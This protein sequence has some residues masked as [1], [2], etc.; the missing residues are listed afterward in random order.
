MNLLAILAALALEQWR[1]FR[2]RNPLERAFVRYARLLE[3]RLNGGSAR[4]GVIAAAVAV[5]P[6]VLVA[7]GVY[8]LLAEL[9]P[10]ADVLWN[11]L[12]LYLLMGFRRFSH[13]FNEIGAA[14]KSGDIVQARRAL[15]HWRGGDTAE[16]SSEEVARLAVERG[17]VDAYRQ[18]F[19]TLFWFTLLPGPAGAVLYRA[20]TLLADEWRDVRAGEEVTP[21]STALARFGMPIRR[22]VWL[23]DWIPVR[24]TALSFAIVGDFE[25]A[26]FCW[27]TQAKE[28]AER[29]GGMPV[30]ILLATGAGAL[31]VVV[32]GTLP[33]EVGEPEFRATLGI[34]EPA[35]ADIL[36]SAVALAW[37]TL[38]LWLLLILLLTLAN[39]AP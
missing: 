8:W 17:L 5:G 34:G 27:R 38:I 32:G 14:L 30:G 15:L 37:R 33:V 4:H 11:V 25:D 2:W 39:L 1:A 36:P 10:L 24:L 3:R 18:V 29:D 13:L 31:G 22:L 20:V 35:S 26:I 19:A 23:L 9:L 7:A 28:W 16:L 12:I 21:I 6:P